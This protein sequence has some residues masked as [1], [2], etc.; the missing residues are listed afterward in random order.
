MI[1]VTVGQ[2]HP[3]DR[4]VRAVDE[5]AT[6]RGRSD[7]FAQVGIGGYRPGAFESVELLEPSEFADRIENASLVVSHAGMGT[8]LSVMQ[9]GTPLL[10]MPRLAKHHETRNDH[11]VAS[12]RMFRERG[13]VATARD[14]GEV[15]A[16][17]DD[18]ESLTPTRRIGSSASDSLLTTI[19]SFIDGENP[20]V[21]IRR[22]NTERRNAA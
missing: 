4:L 1:F 5:W 7:V 17:L 6:R 3:F 8:I 2:M 21:V 13:S 15:M 9:R 18:H 14:G 20:D 19:R 12:A 10:V 16:K 11:Q 22:V